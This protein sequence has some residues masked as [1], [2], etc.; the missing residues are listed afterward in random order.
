MSDTK[1]I[2]TV[3]ILGM[4]LMGGSFG[5]ACL[6]KGLV[7]RVVG[8][9]SDPQATQS[10]LKAGAI[11]DCAFTLAWA[12][13]EADLV[14]I[15]TPV[16]AIPG[17]FAE[18]APFLKAG[19]VVTDVGSTKAGIVQQV[20]DASTAA[21]HFVGGHPVAG[22]ESHGIAAASPDLYDGCFWILTPIKQTAA[23]A[24]AA[25]EEFLGR[26]GAKVLR[27][28]PAKHD[29]AL[30]L[31]SHLPQ[32]L[33]STLMGFAAD[34]ATSGEGLPLLAAGG[35][36]DMTRIAA[37]SPE[38]WVDIVRENQPALL[39]LMKRFERTLAGVTEMLDRQDWEALGKSLHQARE[40][41]RALP[42]KAG[43]DISELEEILV[44]VPDRPGV[45]AEVSTGLRES[46]VN[47]EDLNIV[48]MPEGG[49]GVIHIAVSGSHNAEVAVRALRDR[50]FSV[51]RP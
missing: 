4:G 24:E 1:S 7:E 46:G 40:V 25:L 48:H 51:D 31:T 32:L 5:M 38:M 17:V 20:Q 47:I 28:D 14:V 27:L 22:S 21:V 6:S 3:A 26:L 30:A 42:L 18:A 8:F 12:V 43:M 45:L 19:C 39:G 37:S 2:E 29:E 16:R 11:T 9:D 34:A 49:R 35:F 15:A 13:K 33:S 10:A 36:R 44:A 41:R 50:G 23:E